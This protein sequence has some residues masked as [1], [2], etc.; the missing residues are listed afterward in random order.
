MSETEVL[1]LLSQYREAIEGISN[2]FSQRFAGVNAV[3]DWRRHHLARVGYL[4]G[5]H[6]IE[7]AM[8]GAGCTVGFAQGKLVSFDLDESGNYLFD[9]WKF[10]RYAE[11]IG[12][13]CD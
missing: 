13:K 7:Y 3:R 4:D 2:L 6:T 12:M 11:S 5:N 10:K 1:R 8:H 9:A